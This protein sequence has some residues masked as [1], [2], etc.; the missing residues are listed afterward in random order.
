M[1]RSMSEKLLPLSSSVLTLGDQ[2]EPRA[3]SLCKQLVQE[4]D[5][6]VALGSPFCRRVVPVLDEANPS[7]GELSVCE[8]V[9]SAAHGIGSSEMLKARLHEIVEAS[10]ATG[11]L[12]IHQKADAALHQLKCESALLE[13]GAPRAPARRKLAVEEEADSLAKV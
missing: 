2:F 9:D 7:K 8:E 1:A 6:A 3:P 13:H 11:N 5:Q 10:K 4:M 12:A